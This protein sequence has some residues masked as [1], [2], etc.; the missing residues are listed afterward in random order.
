MDSCKVEPKSIDAAETEDLC[1]SCILV[2]SCADGQSVGVSSVWVSAFC[3]KFYQILLPSVSCP[4]SLFSSLLEPF[5]FFFLFFLFVYVFARSLCGL[6]L[7]R[8]TLLEDSVAA[9]METEPSLEGARE[10]VASSSSAQ[11]SWHIDIHISFG[12][13]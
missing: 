5:F 11:I 10:K 12:M 3:I 4:F 13:Y 1:N 9:P 7:L 6:E 2:P 8:A